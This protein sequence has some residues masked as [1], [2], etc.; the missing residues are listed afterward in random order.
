[1]EG[2]EED[3]GGRER[4]RKMFSKCDCTVL[5]F[6]NTGMN[7]SRELLYG[8]FTVHMDTHAHTLTHACTHTYKPTHV[9]I[10]MSIHRHMH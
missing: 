8:I 4:V 2:V 1:M 10:H 3:G 9:H 6:Q 5:H 7:F